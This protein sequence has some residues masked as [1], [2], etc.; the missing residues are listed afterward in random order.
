MRAV[1]DTCVIVDALQSREPFCK[2]AQSIF[3][4]CANRQFEGFVTAK[5]R[6]THRID[7]LTIYIWIYSLMARLLAGIKVN[8]SG[9]FVVQSFSTSS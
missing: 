5:S 6:P 3:L 4:R 1:I 7:L 9:G 8:G 2:D